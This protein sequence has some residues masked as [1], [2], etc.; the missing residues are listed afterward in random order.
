MIPSRFVLVALAL[1]SMQCHA[2]E[3]AVVVPPALDAGV[4]D[5]SQRDAAP[6]ASPVSTPDA[7]VA[8][9]PTAQDLCL[10][11]GQ[12]VRVT[13]SV[14]GCG[15]KL[16]KTSTDEQRPGVVRLVFA[17]KSSCK[18]MQPVNVELSTDPLQ[19]RRFQLLVEDDGG[20]AYADQMVST[21]TL[22]ACG[23]RKH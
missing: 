19:Q 23:S 12:R 6:D 21:G 22:P 15:L 7:A 2:Q 5:T 8:A 10:D 3:P 9:S 4:G 20:R 17:T 11:P 13:L 16:G 14:P 1:S 18:Q